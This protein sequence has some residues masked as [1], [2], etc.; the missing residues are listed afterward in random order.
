MRYRQPG[1]HILDM[2]HSFATGNECV[3]QHYN[4]FQRPLIGLTEC[5]SGLTLSS[6]SDALCVADR[7]VPA[8]VQGGCTGYGVDPRRLRA[9]GVLS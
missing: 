7:S 1:H 4:A 5:M 6:P 8:G 9:V 2:A 3:Q